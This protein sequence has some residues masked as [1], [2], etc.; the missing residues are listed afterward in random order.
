MSSLLFQLHFNLLNLLRQVVLLA[1]ATLV[2]HKQVTPIYYIHLFHFMLTK[3]LDIYI[4]PFLF[5]GADFFFFPTFVPAQLVQVALV[6]GQTFLVQ[7]PLDNRMYQL[8]LLSS[9]S[10]KV[11]II[12]LCGHPG[13]GR[14][15][16][17]IPCAFCPYVT[18][19]E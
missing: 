19:L 11:T 12:F 6:G 10:I 17:L 1:L 16:T 5:C 8:Y 3:T 9:S 15:T 13:S 7:M 14:I 18:C 2:R 4:W